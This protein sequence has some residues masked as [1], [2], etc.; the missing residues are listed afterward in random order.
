MKTWATNPPAPQP[1]QF[2]GRYYQVVIANNITWQAAKTAAEQ[3][4]LDLGNGVKVKGHL[5]TIGSLEEDQF[6]DQL[7][8][9]TL[10]APHAPITGTELWVGGFQ[11]PC[12]TDA[13]EPGCGWV[14]LNGEAIAEENT[15]SPYTNWQNGEPN[16]LIRIP[17]A[18]SD[19]AENFLAIGLGGASGWNDE[20]FHPNVWGYIIEYGDKVTIAASSCTAGGTGLQPDGHPESDLPS[21]HAGRRKCYFYGAHNSGS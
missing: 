7:R 13:P 19:A 5:A 15:D 16:N 8:R 2:D 3:L 21:R 12:V 10:T 1:V 14:W 11:E 4:E 9:D 18:N 20:G 17:D 6:L